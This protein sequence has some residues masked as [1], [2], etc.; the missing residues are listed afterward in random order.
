MNEWD[1][2][3]DLGFDVEMSAR[4]KHVKIFQTVK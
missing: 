1:Q 4:K 2:L 3:W